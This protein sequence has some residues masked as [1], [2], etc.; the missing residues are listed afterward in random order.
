MG[1]QGQRLGA[2]GHLRVR[3]GRRRQSL[4]TR[5]GGW[6][7]GQGSSHPHQGTCYGGVGC[8]S[9][10]LPSFGLIGISEVPRVWEVAFP[11]GL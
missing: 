2:R 6:S 3:R 1:A 11:S 5:G 8:G 4:Q 9:A 7:L 10:R